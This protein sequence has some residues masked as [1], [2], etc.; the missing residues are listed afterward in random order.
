MV[1]AVGLVCLDQ[2]SARSDEC[3]RKSR[4][5]NTHRYDMR[6]IGILENVHHPEPRDQQIKQKR[7]YFM[8]VLKSWSISLSSRR[9]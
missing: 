2:L 9:L 7:A 5:T 4:S 1:M 8:Y 3:I 6:A